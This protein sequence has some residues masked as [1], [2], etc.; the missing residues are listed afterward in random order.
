MFQGRGGRKNKIIYALPI[1][2]FMRKLPRVSV[3]VLNWNGIHYTL[4]C[5]KAVK[6]QSFRDFELVVVD[7]GS[8]KDGSVEA[9]KKVKGVRLVLNPWNLG[10]AGGN[11]SGVAVASASEYVVLLNNDT[12]VP[13][14]WLGA[15]VS[16]MDKFPRLGSAMS[17]VYNRY[18]KADYR[19]DGYGTTSHLLFTTNYDFSVAESGYVPIFSSSGGAM[20]YRRSLVRLP[21]DSDYFIYHEDGYLGWLLRLKGY[22]AGIIPGSVVRHEGEATIKS[23]KGMGSFFAYLGERNRLMN[24][25]IF[26]SPLT[27]LKLAPFILFT[28]LFMNFYDFRKAP[29]RLRSYLWLL[30]HFPK[31]LEKRFRI[32]AQRKVPDSKIACFMSAKLFEPAHFSSSF[33]KRVVKLLNAFSFAYCRLTGIKSV[34]LNREEVFKSV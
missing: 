20:I 3:I 22:H 29:F 9:L 32:Q 17:K 31:V 12:V 24:L 11:N 4:P 18:D 25:F 27:L 14:D 26:Y 34:E 15:L 19:F 5:I 23:V 8:T 13:K 1:A 16:A 7:N 33:A 30:V 6:G 21:F 28:V 10:F 2:F